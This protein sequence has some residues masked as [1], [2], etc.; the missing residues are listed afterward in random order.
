MGKESRK[1]GAVSAA[2]FGST[3]IL[4]IMYLYIKMLGSAGL[5]TFFTRSFEAIEKG[6]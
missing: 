4:S 1:N 6:L 5:N 2:Q 3:S